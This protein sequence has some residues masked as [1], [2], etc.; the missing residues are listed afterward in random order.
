[1][2]GVTGMDIPRDIYF[3]KELQFRLSRSYGPGRY[4]ALYEE[5]TSTIPSATCAGPRGATS[6]R[7]WT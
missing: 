3:A 6:T 2:V 4:D 1:M 5:G 7:S